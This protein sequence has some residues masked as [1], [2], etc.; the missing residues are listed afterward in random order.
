MASR[1]VNLKRK[2]AIREKTILSY[3]I[4]INLK[5]ASEK[6]TALEGRFV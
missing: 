2:G 1:G 3:V 4:K 6:D 5:T